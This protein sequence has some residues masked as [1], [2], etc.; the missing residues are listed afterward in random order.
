MEI[1][2]KTNHYE[3]AFASWLGDNKLRF[4]TVDQH[5]RATFAKAKIK[6]FDF[7]ISLPKQQSTMLAEVKGRIFK[8]TSLEKRANLQCWVTMED[9]K[10]LCKWRDVFG[11]QYSASIIF[12][13]QI[14]KPDVDTDGNEIYEFAGNRY[15]F[16]LV[17]LEDYTQH[18]ALRSTKWQTVSMPA[19]KFRHCAQRADLAL[20]G[21]FRAIL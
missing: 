17:S 14:E 13:Y 10:G 6:S 4:I 7:I 3:Q 18:M 8:G 9:I 12:V 19:D 16:F 1:R 20:L 21:D 11:E 2:N 15:F 5:K